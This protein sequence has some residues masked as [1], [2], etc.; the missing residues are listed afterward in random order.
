MKY[1]LKVN[2][3]TS[4]G[5]HLVGI[6]VG[7]FL[8]PYV[9]TT[10]GDSQYGLWLFICSFAGYT[11]LLNLGFGETVSRFVAHHHAK[12]ETTQI[13]QVVSVIG[14]VYLGM[15]ILLVSLAGILA[16]FAPL[17]Y[18]WGTTSITEI[19]WVFVLLG[20]NV[21]IGMLG[22]VF[23]GVIVGLQRIDLERGFRT[24]SGLARLGMTVLLLQKEHALITLAVIFLLT[25]L[26]ENIGYLAVVFRQMPELR[27]H[28][29]YL[30]RGT[31][32][33]CFSFSVFALLENIAS[34]LIDATD[35]I[36]IGLML[37]TRYI[38][39]YF[40]AH[41]MMTFIVQPLQ[42]IG[43][44]VMPRGAELEANEHT[45]RLR[46]L[47]QKGL[48]LSFLLTAGFFIGAW[49]F[50]ELVLE[51]WVG[52]SYGESHLILLILLGAQVV[53]TP[54]HVLRGALFGMG[55]V[56]VP[57]I[58]YFIE[59]IANLLLTLLLLK[60]FGIVG[61]AMGTAIPIVVV[62]LCFL[63]PYALS[64]LHFPKARF[65]Q[66]VVMPQVLP[67]AALWVYSFAVG[68][69]FVISPS[70]IPVL[71]VASGGGAVLGVSW[72][73]SRYATRN[74]LPV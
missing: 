2:L 69:T 3:L 17:L 64:V 25:T 29:Q 41:R 53:A 19:R 4:W 54:L 5:D 61:V 68:V 34:R 38:I 50:G 67:L 21:A 70:W 73:A 42:M 10:V 35:T 11:G 48:G 51:T 39:P 74:W 72:L 47:V 56:K 65:L 8:M 31:L 33:E 55:R 32:K 20:V 13:N 40:V 36:V 18:D 58:L 60:P 7:L 46:V 14:A 30:S 43:M 12:N 6:L 22:S 71:L 45:D 23:G 28:W 49:F 37:G 1:K 24:L 57:A 44:I 27:I 16:W 59:A 26:I 9:L 15:S 63:L 62:E 52:R 66:G